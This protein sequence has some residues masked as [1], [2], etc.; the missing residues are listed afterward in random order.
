MPAL[1]RRGNEWLARNPDWEA[2]TCESGD[3]RASRRVPAK[4]ITCRRSGEGSTAHVRCLRL[5]VRQRTRPDR[6]PQQLSHLNFVP[7]VV[8]RKKFGTP[9]FLPLGDMVQKM[10]EMLRTNPLPGRIITIETQETMAGVDPD[11]TYWTESAEATKLFVFVIRIFFQTGF[12]GRGTWEPQEIGLADFRPV[13][14]RPGGAFSGNVF[15]PLRRSSHPRYESFSSLAGRMSAWCLGQS[16][17]RIANVQSIKYKLKHG[18][19]DTRRT[20]YT[21][22]GYAATFYVRILRVAHVRAWEVH[23]PPVAVTCRTF[24]PVQLERVNDV[25]PN[26]K[27]SILGGKKPQ[28]PSRQW[29]L[30]FVFYPSSFVSSAG[31]LGRGSVDEDEDE[32]VSRT[33]DRVAVWMWMTGANFI[34]AQTS[35]VRLDDGSR[36]KGIS[37]RKD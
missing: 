23:L 34:S 6:V 10:N 35:A 5:W 15:C 33:R 27:T 4:E 36:K 30:P 13:C 26:G 17:I 31:G 32:D 24:S 9:K 29:R 18:E 12:S 16:D 21:E 14:E 2:A 37:C 20:W 22:H 7:D 11:R 25:E 8:D 19:T 1:M 28:V 3:F